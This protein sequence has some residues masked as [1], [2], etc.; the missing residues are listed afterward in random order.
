MA[1]LRYFQ[2][3]AFLPTA[4]E[5]AIGNTVTQSANAAVLREMQAE[6]LRKREPYTVSTAEQR[7]TIE[8]YASEHGNAAQ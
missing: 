4:E 8:K 7:A 2:V 6:W 1:L 5:T 3:T